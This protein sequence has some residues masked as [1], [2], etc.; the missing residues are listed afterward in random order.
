MFLSRQFARLFFRPSSWPASFARL[1]GWMSALTL[2][3]RPEI[4]GRPS[5]TRI[6]CVQARTLRVN[7]RKKGP[8]A[9]PTSPLERTY[10][11]ARRDC[12]VSA[13]CAASSR[14][15]TRNPFWMP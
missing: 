6:A 12:D 13:P 3:M 1:I 5:C 7:Q 11:T 4:R 15:K 14:P 9:A 8:P 2:A 10:A